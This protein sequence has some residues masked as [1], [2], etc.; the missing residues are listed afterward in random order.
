[1]AA[2]AMAARA[3]IFFSFATAPAWFRTPASAGVRKLGRDAHRLLLMRRGR[4]N[5]FGKSRVRPAVVDSIEPQDSAGCPH[6]RRIP[7][8]REL[9]ECAV[10]CFYRCCSPAYLAPGPLACPRKPSQQRTPKCIFPPRVVRSLH[11]RPRCSLGISSFA[12]LQT[13]SCTCLSSCG[14]RF[15]N[16]WGWTCLSQVLSKFSVFLNGGKEL[17]YRVCC[18]VRFVLHQGQVVNIEKNR[19]RCQVSLLSKRD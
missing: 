13:L 7:G 17:V 6:R 12:G 14:F 15:K 3:G 11:A 1:M 9:L 18:V 19:G 5:L 8:S 2:R 16:L 10:L 4:W